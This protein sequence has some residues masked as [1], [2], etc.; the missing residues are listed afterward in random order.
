M[1]TTRFIPA[2]E[3]ESRRL[4]IVLHGLGDS[5]EGHA[6][7]PRAL[8]LPW[9]NFL[10]VNAPDPW[11]GG[12]SWFDIE[13]GAGIPRSRHLLFQLLDSLGEFPSEQILFSGF[14]QGCL[15]SI[16]VGTRYHRLLAGIVGISGFVHEPEQLIREFSPVARQQRFLITH[17]V[18][19]PLIPIAT[20]RPQIAL[21]RKAGLQIDW[22]E[23]DK[24]HTIAG[25]EELA[26]IRQFVRDC[27]V[28]SS[29]Q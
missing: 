6:F 19:D 13:T 1:L 8:G 14:S 18:Q 10:L 5:M 26:V 9:L 25:E 23:F 15:M 2:V 22:R 3:T 29:D 11:Y 7:W 28:N 17:G 12:F 16:E 24:G 4:M 20:A 21:L 27:Y